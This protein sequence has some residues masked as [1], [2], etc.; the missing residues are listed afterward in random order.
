SHALLE[1]LGEAVENFASRPSVGFVPVVDGEVAQVGA[2]RLK[3]G[4]VGLEEEHV[5]RVQG[6]EITS[7]KIAGNRTI[8]GLAGIMPLLQQF[9][10]YASDAPI[11]RAGRYWR[12]SGGFFGSL[13]L[14]GFISGIQREGQHPVQRN[15]K[16]PSYKT[17]DHDL[18]VY[19][20]NTTPVAEC[21]HKSSFWEGFF[22]SVLV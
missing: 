18:Q 8:E 16:D 9:G 22:P 14:G 19:W 17:F 11:Q 1:P 3:L 4:E 15:E 6:F 21:T 12:K 10:R 13:S 7:E 2:V 20:E 5:L